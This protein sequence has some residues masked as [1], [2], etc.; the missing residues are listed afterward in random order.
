MNTYSRTWEIAWLVAGVA[1]LAFFAIW[2]ET[3]P[4]SLHVWT[5]E[6]GPI[7][8]MTSALFGVSCLFFAL[9]AWRSRYLKERGGRFYFFAMAWAALMFVF[10]GEEV[11]WGQRIFDFDTPEGVKK[12]N[13][14]KEMN[15][16]NLEAMQVFMGG[17]FR[18]LS[19]MML[20]TGLGFP[21]LALTAFGK[22][23]LQKLAFPVAPVLLFPFFLGAYLFG[24][25]YW[26]VILNDAAEV[27]EFVMSVGMV[28]FAWTGARFPCRLFRVCDPRGPASE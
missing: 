13:L 21:L 14:Q 26:P 7:E 8:S 6:D 23:W 17:K 18:Y 3:D 11:S 12:A 4:D 25:H 5:K 27:R 16:H 15:I 10:M 22:R 20:A 1:L 2:T 19:I 24:R 28:A 9:F